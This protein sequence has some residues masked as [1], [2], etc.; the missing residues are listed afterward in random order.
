MQYLQ[1]GIICLKKRK[2]K[3]KGNKSISKSK[4]YVCI[5]LKEHI[6]LF[7]YLFIEMNLLIHYVNSIS[8]YVEAITC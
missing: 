7:I 6:Y 1:K 8:P 4:I 3:R 2:E 5:R